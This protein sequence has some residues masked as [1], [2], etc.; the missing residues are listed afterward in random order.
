MWT[1]HVEV[2]FYLALPLIGWAITR[3]ARRWSLSGPLALC[4]DAHRRERRV[5]RTELRGRL[6][7]RGDV[8]AAD[9][10]RRLRVRDRRRDPR[11]RPHAAPDPRPGPRARRRIARPAQRRSGTAGVR[12]AQPGP[13]SGDLPASI[14]FAAIVAAVALRPSR[15]LGVAP[16][17]VL[18]A[19]SLGVYLWHMPVLY[20]LQVHDLMPETFWAALPRVL[21]P[22]PGAGRRQLGARRAPGAALEREVHAALGSREPAGPGRG[23]MI[24]PRCGACGSPSSAT[25]SRRTSGGS[26]TARSSAS[27]SSSRSRPIRRAPAPSSR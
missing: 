8:D 13:S 23:A 11:P 18:G 19:I 20:A 5:G 27:R 2:S 25:S 12:P 17:R 9:V 16:L 10:P 7:A 4:V 26:C 6:G 24:P 3:L 15:I 14:G 1:M 22:G 21:V